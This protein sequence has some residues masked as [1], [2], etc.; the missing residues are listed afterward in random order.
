ML[1]QPANSFLF[2]STWFILGYMLPLALFVVL[3]LLNQK[4]IKENADLSRVRN[5]KANKV[6]R[7]RLKKSALLLKKG[8]KEGFY[9]ELARALWG[10]VSDK[11][12][13]PRASLT[14]DKV[15]SALMDN[16]A[17]AERREE[18]RQIPDTSEYAR[19]SAK[20]E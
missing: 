7:R 9:E 17:S 2:G 12:S 18:V 8:D 13:I 4:R 20:R 16:G 11:L 10:Y 1:L 6:A 5:R 3:F 14:K 19:L 15:R